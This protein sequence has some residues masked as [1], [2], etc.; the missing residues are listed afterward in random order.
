MS[1]TNFKI[2]AFSG[3]MTIADG[4]V[5][6]PQIPFVK[7]EKVKS[8]AFP[9]SITRVEDYTFA[10][11]YALTSVTLNDGLTYIGKQAFA[12]CAKLEEIKIPSTVTQ[13][14][15]TPFYNCRKLSKVYVAKN[16]TLDKEALVKDANG[17]VEVVEY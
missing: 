16:S 3:V 5:S 9:Q 14:G 15:E 13:I 7:K 10:N 12:S 4:E 17:K 1:K 11:C 8:V 6:V 2:S